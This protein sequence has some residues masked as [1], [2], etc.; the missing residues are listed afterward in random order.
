[1]SHEFDIA[2][3]GMAGRWPGARTL[4]EFWRNLADGIESIT[5][6]SDEEL[7]QAGVSRSQLSD[8]HYVKAAPVLDDPGHFDAAF[9]G[10]SPLEARMMDPQH[11]ILLEIGHEALEHAGYDPDRFQGRIGVFTGSAMNTYFMAN[12]LNRRFAEEYIPTLIG[13]D[14]D[15]LSTRISYKLNLGGPSIT[16]QTACS[17]S[18]VAVHLARQSLLS[19][20][21]DMAMAGAI[22]VRVPH[23]AGYVHDAGG[24]VSADGHVRAFDAS[25]NGTV[26]GSGGGMLVLRRLADAIAN[27]DT[28]HA[29]IM[30][31]AVNN[32]GSQKAGYTAPSVNGQ[33]DVVVEALAN[34]GVDAD[35]LSYVEGHGSGTP[36]GDPIEIK[37]LTNAFRASTQR[38]GFCAIGSVKTNIGHL[39][40]A[41]G[42]AGIIKTVLALKH[43]QLPPTL[44]FKEANPEIDFAKTPFYVNTRLM[45]W[46]S[47]GP[48]RAGVMATGMGGTNAYV[49]LEQAPEALPATNASSPHLLVLSAKT[50]TALEQAT[51]RL[52]DFLEREP[53]SNLDEVA[54]T[55]QLGRKAFPH[56]RA[57][58]CVDRQDAI[59]ALSG[60][61][62]QR[63]HSGW[64]DGSARRPVIFLLAGIGDHYVGM[65]HGLYETWE[66][67][68]NEVDR[69][70]H[71]LESHLGVD[72]RE[73]IYPRTEGWKKKGTTP[74][75]DFKKMLGRHADADP[76]TAALNT[77][78]FAQPALFAIEYALARLWQSWGVTPDA[79]IGH[80]MGEYV[81]A[82]LSGVLSLEDA[83]RLIAVRAR[84]VNALPQGGMLAVMLSETDLRPQL[85]DSLSIALINGPRLCVVAGPVEAVASFETRLTEAG[86]ISRRIQNAHAF[87]TRMLNPI[88]EAFEAE[89]AKVAL[90]KPTIPFVS[91]LTGTWITDSQATDPAYWAK[92]AV[93]T[94]RFSDALQTLWQQKDAIVIEVGPGRTLGVLAMEHPDRIHAADPVVVPSV[95]HHY[96]HGS[97][98]AF[99]LQSVGR[100]W[101]KGLSIDWERLHPAGPARR[102]ALPT[103]PF[104]RQDYWLQPESRTSRRRPSRTRDS[105]AH[106]IDRWFYTPTWERTRVPAAQGEPRPDKATWLIVGDRYG[107]GAAIKALLDR[108]GIAAVLV[109][110]G[111]DF[112]RRGDGSV[113]V[114]PTR[115]DHYRQLLKP[116][117]ADSAAPLNIVHLGALT[118]T[119]SPTA[120]SALNQ[121]YSFNSLLYI[122]QAIGDLG[123]SV[124]VTIGVVSNGLHDVTGEEALHPGMATVLGACGVIPKE[125]PNVRCF[126]VDL[127]DDQKI[128]DQPQDLLIRIVSEF[129]A[130]PR[131]HVLAYRG[132]YRWQ[133]RFRHVG[134]PA[135]RADRVTNEPAQNQP[136][137]RR[138]VYLITGGAGGIGLV[139]ARYLATTCQ[140]SLV[141][142]KR[143]PLPARSMWPTLAASA[144]T[145]SALRTTLGALLDLEAAGAAVEVVVADVADQAQMREVRDRMR[146][147]Y[148]AI[149]GV[150][151]AA[152]TV[153]DG[154]IQVKTKEHVESVLAPKLYG[155]VVLFELFK[156]SALDFLVLF[157]SMTSILTPYGVAEY[158]GANA[159]LDAF[160]AF[161]N[162]QARFRTLTINW[163]GWK[164]VGQL[165]NLKIA[166]G[167]EGVKAAL[168]QRAIRPEDGLEAFKR[169]L[170]SD[171]RHVFVSPDN[172]HRLLKESHAPFDSTQLLGLAKGGGVMSPEQAPATGRAPASPPTVVSFDPRNQAVLPRTPTER[173]LGE[174]W[175]EVLGTGTPDIHASFFDLGGHSLLAIKLFA[176]IEER[177]GRRLPLATL[178]EHPTIAQLASIVDPGAPPAKVTPDPLVKIKPGGTK[179]PFFC[180]HGIGGEVLPFQPLAGSLSAEQPFYGL[181]WAGDDAGPRFPNIETL[182]TRYIKA[183]RRVMPGGPYLLGGYCSG[184]LIAWEMAQQLRAAGDHVGLVVLIDHALPTIAARF[185][186]TK[187][188]RNLPYWVTDD[189]ARVTPEQ[190]AA[191][192]RGKINLLLD[193]R[194]SAQKQ[195]SGIRDVLGMWNAPESA[196]DWIEG[197]YQQQLAYHPQPYA[198][199]VTILRA[200][201]LPLL[202]PHRAP[203]FGWEKLATGRA[204][205]HRIPGSHDSILQEPWV[206]RLAAHLQAELDM[207]CD[208]PASREIRLDAPVAV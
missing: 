77:T 83:L 184:S 57:V 132:R 73:L 95:R 193:W 102:I 113:E 90:D 82:C 127:A 5:R 80:S 120:A 202:S 29:V 105:D 164:D 201:A 45:D 155:S 138:G 38:S 196:I 162:R 144:E 100:V 176:K 117:T 70:A 147:R 131:S 108:R 109:R 74:G 150:I 165:A 133:R 69:C 37:A 93:H 140:A 44:H 110:F 185:T 157:S 75:I 58:V 99:V 203:E 21:T 152:G 198:G 194:N 146:S 122:A 1:M 142:T 186:V 16:V 159:F 14:K 169:I 26:F 204:R 40:A 160:G 35:S 126:N 24:I 174:I 180:V 36:V 175:R 199:D 206:R 116:L 149:H 172:L 112:A 188:L 136:L 173:V 10:F 167:L 60:I 106:G 64:T 11:R 123:L 62:N 7:L 4:D 197:Q 50:E 71:I 205:V 25:A 31:T 85:T 86:I 107:G 41:A 139:I 18:L 79:M 151:H 187:F 15:F 43:R 98:V 101:S 124:P 148:G 78:L 192:L 158:S 51:H 125:F 20:E 56:R 94:V 130:P 181:Q 200:R 207:V 163:P 183:I 115:G 141:L 52:R 118:R 59:A 3:I 88:Q 33:C 178:F 2:I 46:T 190:F 208:T 170:H 191:R 66:T 54:S 168:L 143:T 87:H 156:D 92:H 153:R 27:G 6:F 177:F 145:P 39:D 119:G 12:R 84:L 65:A 61:D 91:S 195:R 114:N 182:A 32:D 42:V 89:V 22:S 19:G 53:L 134:V 8:R 104:E 76:D 81:A 189:L 166:A 103:Y 17:T 34:A 154:L 13:S 135:L 72:I 171:L 121:D 97:D 30:G 179:P 96:E 67:F 128:D 161:A 129:S 48:R 28:I 137:R 9:F 68:R 47:D 111:E 23:R 63:G 49:V 55:L